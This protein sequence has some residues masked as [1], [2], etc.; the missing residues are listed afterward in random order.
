MSKCE[1]CENEADVIEYLQTNETGVLIMRTEVLDSKESD[2]VIAVNDKGAITE[3]KGTGERIGAAIS[4]L[5]STYAIA[6]AKTVRES[7][8]SEEEAQRAVSDAIETTLLTAL[9]SIA[10]E[11][12]MEAVDEGIDSCIEDST[13]WI[14]EIEGR[15]VAS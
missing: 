3:F 13:D 5:M 1:T 8:R 9:I 12:I 15:G 4:A 11:S 14:E 6:L 7:G 10:D 2:R